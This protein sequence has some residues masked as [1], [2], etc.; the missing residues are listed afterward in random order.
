ME[1]PNFQS[2]DGHRLFF[3]L[4]SA[5]FCVFTRVNYMYVLGFIDDSN[6]W[7]NLVIGK[8]LGDFRVFFVGFQCFRLSGVKLFFP[9]N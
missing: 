8:F 5:I 9:H 7:S 4:F 3:R 6:L 2:D 1:N